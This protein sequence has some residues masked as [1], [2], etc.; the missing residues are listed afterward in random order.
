M[1]ELSQLGFLFNIFTTKLWSSKKEDEDVT[2]GRRKSETGNND[3][4]PHRR[5][6]RTQP[7]R[8][9]TLT[10][11]RSR[12]RA[13]TPEGA[14]RVGEHHVAVCGVLQTSEG[15]IGD[16]ILPISSGCLAMSADGAPCA[17]KIAATVLDHSHA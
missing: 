16:M 1:P 11:G 17:N 3:A 7:R 15:R 14:H 12:H 5:H 10:K 2:D 9:Q 13:V 4:P 8:H 6:S